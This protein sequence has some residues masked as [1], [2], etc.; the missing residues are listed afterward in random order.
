MRLN[1]TPSASTLASGYLILFRCLEEAL[2]LLANILCIL[3]VLQVLLSSPTDTKFWYAAPEQ[4]C[5][6]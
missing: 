2:Y 5:P 6:C 4:L 3:M 1:D